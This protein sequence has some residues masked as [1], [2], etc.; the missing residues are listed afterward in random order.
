[1]NKFERSWLLFRSSLQVIIRNKELLL[2]PVVTSICSVVILL[3]FLAPAALWPTS[4]SYFSSEHWKDLFNVFFQK[5]NSHGTHQF[6]Y[7][8]VAIGYVVFL[9]FVS[10]FIATF[11]N[12]AFY[13]EILAALSGEPVS[14]IRGLKFASSRWKAILM[15]TLFAGLIGLIIKMIEQ[16][17]DIVGKLIARFIGVAWSIAAVFAIPVI[18]R[19]EETANPFVILKKSAIAL[20]QTWGESLIGY[21]GIGAINSIV[22]FGSTVVLL[23]SIA[24]TAQMHAPWLL[25][26]SIVGWLAFIVAWS[27]LMNVASLVYKGA[28]FLY[29]AEGTIAEPYEQEM[30]DS[31]WK[32]KKQS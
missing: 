1:M 8:P 20:T 19:D 26:F 21:V 5:T 7:S 16:R 31:A 24:A 30:L 10:M 23:V 18:V 25:G 13:N 15:W 12:V 32:Y 14:L 28:L 6:T 22:A 3:F 17:L 2:F 9:Y 27:Y 11:F 4:H 29:A